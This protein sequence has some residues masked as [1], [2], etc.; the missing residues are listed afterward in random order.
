MPNAFSLL[1][2]KLYKLLWFVFCSFPLI[3]A[4]LLV[5]TDAVSLF[6]C[7]VPSLELFLDVNVTLASGSQMMKF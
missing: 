2:I 6:L 4:H 1:V 3:S 7:V 5:F